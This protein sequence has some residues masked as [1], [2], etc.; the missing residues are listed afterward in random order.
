MAVT[1]DVLVLGLGAAG[2]AA[3]WQCAARGARVIGIDRWAPPHDRGSSFGRTRIIREAYYEHPLYVPFLR[4]SLDLWRALETESGRTLL[5]T[6]GGAMIGP[7]DGELVAGA[8]SSAREH[9]IAHELLDA[10][11]FESRFPGYQL[12]PDWVALVENRAGLLLPEA[13]IESFHACARAR[14]AEL[15][16]D[17]RAIAWKADSNGVV[18]ETDQQRYH[19]SRLVIAA[20]AWLPQ[21]VPELAPVLQIERQVLMWFDPARKAERFDAEHSPIALWEFERGR[22]FATFPDLGDGFKAGL[23]HGGPTCDPETLER[24]PI[25]ADE[26]AI[27]WLLAR[28]A[29]DT[30]GALRDACVC[31]YTNTPDHHFVIDRHPYHEQVVIASACSGH[32]FKFASATGEMI[33]QLTLDGRTQLD[34]APFAVQR[35]LRE[36][37]VQ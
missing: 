18:V 25:K 7:P 15:R 29:P 34:L 2:S 20:G 6:T 27:R 28:L 31:M 11:S 3:A 26:R 4:R 17:E 19:A 10:P 13:C 33:A 1:A 35:L 32:G 36:A 30:N 21:L 22:I 37:P 9:G 12:Q 8:L 23:H 16:T 14:G 24:S 5:V